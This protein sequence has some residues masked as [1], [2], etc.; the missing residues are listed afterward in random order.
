MKR[1]VGDLRELVGLYSNQPTD[2]GDVITGFIRQQW[3]RIEPAG[4]RAV[5]IGAV[6]G[7]NETHK[8]T[9]RHLPTVQTGWWLKDAEGQVYELMNGNTNRREDQVYWAKLINPAGIVSP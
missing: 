2:A 7:S 1:D 9:F 5:E 6:T 4:G 3:C 8:V